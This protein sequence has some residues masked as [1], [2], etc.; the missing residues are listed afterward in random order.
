MKTSKL[1]YVLIAS[2][3]AVSITA[4]SVYSCEKEVITPVNEI[5]AD[6]ERSA[7][8][9]KF[10]VA[11]PSTVCGVV[12]EEYLVT[13][14]GRKVGKAFYWNDAHNFHLIMLTVRGYEMSAANMHIMQSPAEFPLNDQKNPAIDKFEYRIDAPGYTHKREF[15][16]PMKDLVE[17]NYIAA[18]VSVKMIK[19]ITTERDIE[20]NP[21]IPG[22]M[23]RLWVDGR[24]QGVNR[25]GKIFIFERTRCELP[26]GNQITDSKGITNL[27]DDHTISNEKGVT[28]LGEGHTTTDPKKPR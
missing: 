16:V 15:V 26:D 8:Q 14:E 4:V 3:A 27:G 9:L 7:T 1:K 25:K 22:N 11:D 12:S 13:N 20:I 6:T 18:T 28:A 2:L 23:I 19:D 5:S 21:E 10:T 17:R 24:S